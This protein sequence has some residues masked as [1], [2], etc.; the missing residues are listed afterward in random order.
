MPTVSGSSVQGRAELGPAGGG[1]GRTAFICRSAAL[2]G[3]FF[4]FRLLAGDLSD[5][6]LFL[7]TLGAA[8]LVPVLLKKHRVPALQGV[9]VLVLL[10]WAARLFLALP[11]VFVPGTGVFWDALLLGLDRNNFVSLPPYYWIALSSFFCLGSRRFLRGD[12][13][14]QGLLLLAVFLAAR[15]AD[16]EAYR[17]PALTLGCFGALVFFQILA[18]IFSA[19]PAYR[20]N[21]AEKV[22]ASALMFV[23]VFSGACLLI[24]PFEEKAVDQS[25]GLLQPKMFSFDFSQF[26]RLESEISMNTDLVL[27]VRKEGRFDHILIRR[28]ILSAYSPGRGFYMD[29]N[30]DEAEHP[31]RLP[32]GTWNT[33]VTPFLRSDAPV[34]MVDQEYYLVNFDSQAFIALNQPEEITPFKTWD[35]SSFNSAYAVRSRVNEALSFELADTV[36]DIPGEEYSGLDSASYRYYTDYGNDPRIAAKAGEFTQGVRGYGDRVM[37]IH[38][39][40]KYGEYRYSLKPGIAVDGDQ[41]GY[42]L[43]DVKKGY[44]SYFAFAMTLLLRSQGIPARVAAG[45]FIDP[46]EGAF[47]YYPVRQDMAHAWV[48]VWFPGYGWV[49]YDPTSA[50]FAAGEDFEFSS[51][52]SRDQFEK[53]MEE[54]L[55]NRTLLEVRSGGAEEESFFETLGKRAVFLAGLS[56]PWLL[57]GALVIPFLALRL[58]HLVVLLFTVSARKKTLRLWAQVSRRLALAGLRRGQDESEGEW[59]KGL[60]RAYHFNL[61]EM[62]LA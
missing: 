29:E 25:G 22:R 18:F 15:T 58:G 23:L 49:E 10:P 35:A 57:A 37:M 50:N 61:Y 51:G 9:I 24:R 5:T 2:F 21:T 33:S 31:A 30:R 11:R 14:A 32:Q 53:L 52:I 60:D 36:R 6:S 34:R 8:F 4:Q 3:I 7:T 27:I 62:Y 40:L 41:L 28:F 47:D 44:C 16:M 38:D 17:L 19:D 20:A 46:E 56:W 45:F 1:P 26:I 39:A 43:F 42:F 48:E 54:I 55:K 13:I 12:L 59:V